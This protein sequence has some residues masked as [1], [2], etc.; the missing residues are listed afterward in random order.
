MA[1][2]VVAPIIDFTHDELQYLNLIRSVLENGE[3]RSDHTG[4]DT[5]SLFAPQSLRFSLADSML[6]LFTTT[7]IVPREIIEELL[8]LV[9]GN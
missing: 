1:R 9:K 3:S 8:W 7:K 4:A 2:K 6:P 5:I